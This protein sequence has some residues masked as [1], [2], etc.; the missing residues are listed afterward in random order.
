MNPDLLEFTRL[1]PRRF[2]PSTA[3]DVPVMKDAFGEAHKYD[4]AGNLVRVPGAIE[5][6]SGNQ[7]RFPFGGS[8]ESIEHPGLNWSRGGEEWPRTIREGVRLGHLRPDT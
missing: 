4:R 8:R 2:P 3:R 1:S 7:R 5:R 6:H